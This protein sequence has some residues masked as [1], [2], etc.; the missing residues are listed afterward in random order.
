MNGKDSQIANLISNY[1][2]IHKDIGTLNKIV[3]TNYF[4]ISMPK[5]GTTSLKKG[6]INLN[7][8]VIHTHTNETGY[9]SLSN[10][11]LLRKN[12]LGMDSFIQYRLK[13]NT[14]PIYIFSGYREPISWYISLSQQF[15]IEL[16][17][18]L[19]E[20]IIY[21]LKEKSPWKNYLPDEQFRLI[22]KCAGIKLEDHVFDKEKGFYHIKNGKLNLLLYRIDA[23][24]ELE[25]YISENILPGYKLVTGR[26]NDNSLY[27]NFKRNFKLSPLQ[28]D[29]VYNFPYLN[30]FYKNSAIDALKA[31]FI[32]D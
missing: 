19:K 13:K 15:K 16:T 12:Q 8:N 21:N 24:S 9:K 7:E 14:A 10:G 30:Y 22:E 23:L 26:V 3:D 17:D 28:I 20:N 29:E 11:Q 25:K 6:F 27:V 31:K 18:S 1:E 4:V 32:Q 5:C 2:F